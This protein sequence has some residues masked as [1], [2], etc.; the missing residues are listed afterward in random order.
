MDKEIS[1]TMSYQKIHLNLHKKIAV[2]R[3]TSRHG[4]TI[5]IYSFF[6]IMNL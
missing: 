6:Y 2:S 3:F 4:D 1:G 5:I